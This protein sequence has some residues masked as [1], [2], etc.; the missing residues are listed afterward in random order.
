MGII[1]RYAM[2]AK[3]LK[4]GLSKASARTES[5]PLFMIVSSETLN[6]V[7]IVEDKLLYLSLRLN[8]ASWM[9]VV[10]SI[11]ILG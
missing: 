3:T 10:L 2:K 8:K 4:V 9:K 7:L 6:E 5:I 11:L 1:S